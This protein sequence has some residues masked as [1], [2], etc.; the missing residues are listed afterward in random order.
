MRC[1]RA[2]STRWS[3]SSR[4]APWTA[5][6]RRRRDPPAIGARVKR[7]TMAQ[8]LV[9]FLAQQYVERDG[10]EQ[11]FFA[12]CWGILGHGNVAGIGQALAQHPEAL[13]Y[14]QARN[15]QSMVH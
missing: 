10:V 13:R 11:R 8:A 6:R 9:R 1:T 12:G 14:H 3:R 7:L 5:G 4:P 2:G 15:E